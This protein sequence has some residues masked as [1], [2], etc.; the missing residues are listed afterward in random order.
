MNRKERRCKVMTERRCDNCE[1]WKRDGIDGICKAKAPSP[2]IVFISNQ[3]KSG[4]LKLVEPRKE[5]HDYCFD[6]FRPIEEG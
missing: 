5:P 2:G 3:D 4:D 1:C 6:S